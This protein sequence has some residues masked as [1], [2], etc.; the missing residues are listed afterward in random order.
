M[1]RNQSI[2]SRVEALIEN[3]G[4]TASWLARQ[5]GLQRSTISRLLRGHRTPSQITLDAIAKALG[6]SVA[7]LVAGTDLVLGAAAASAPAKAA[8]KAG[9]AAKKA[10]KKA[11]KAAKKAGK[12]VGKAAKKAG[13]KVG[14][15]AKKAGKKVKKAAKKAARR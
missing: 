4:W 12:K 6:L 8:K 7:R 9:K 1:P 11:G 14:K 10:G 5:A 3:A 13:K 15:A 2:R